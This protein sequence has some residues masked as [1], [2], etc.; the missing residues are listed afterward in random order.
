MIP[1]ATRNSATRCSFGVRDKLFKIEI[2]SLGIGGTEFR[3]K[4]MAKATHEAQWQ[5]ILCEVSWKFLTAARH[6][7]NTSEQGAIYR[8]RH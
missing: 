5:R 3:I 7:C 1:R 6:Q 4:Q 8:V 2:V